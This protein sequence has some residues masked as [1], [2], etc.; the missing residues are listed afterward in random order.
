MILNHKAM[1][2]DFMIKWVKWLTASM[3]LLLVL[4][5]CGSAREESNSAASAPMES[6][7]NSGD[8]A[9]DTGSG[10]SEKSIIEDQKST[11]VNNV[12]VETESESEGL[13]STAAKGGNLTTST[14]FSAADNIAGLNKK[15]IYTANVT[16][17]VKDYGKAQS[18]IRNLVTLAGGYIVE[19]SEG[20]SYNEEG[21]NFTIK[22]PASGFSTFLDRLDKLEHED[23]QRSIQ[24]QDVSEEYVDL[25]SRLKVKLAME[26]RY[27]KFLNEA[28]KTTQIVEFVN[29]LERIQTEIE[30]I[31]GRM[32]FIDNSVT[33]STIEIR[34]YQPYSVIVADKTDKPLFERAQDALNG[35][36]NVVITLFQWIVIVVSAAIPVLLI[37]GI[38]VGIVWAFL[39][40]RRRKT[41]I[42]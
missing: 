36:M 28:T 16:M 17:E 37:A 29:E 26:E 2:A 30:Q 19:F 8:Y 24:G 27:L 42:E 6:S 14:G 11:S 41:P 38:V 20:S 18:D 35:S 15:L 13:P 12:A 22:V 3:V 34:L 5:G 7:D 33:F 23:M 31:R 32:R 4:S 1:G 40:K 10:T 39:R 9:A 21:G 25:E